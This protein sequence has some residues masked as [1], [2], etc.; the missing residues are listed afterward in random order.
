MHANNISDS[1]VLR[2]EGNKALISGCRIAVTISVAGFH[3]A[4]GTILL[5]R[6]R[7]DSASARSVL[8]AG[9]I[10]APGVASTQLCFAR[11]TFALF[12]GPS[13][14]AVANNVALLD[15]AEGFIELATGDAANFS[16]IV[17]NLGVHAAPFLLFFLAFVTALDINTDGLAVF[18]GL[19]RARVGVLA[20]E[21]FSQAGGTNTIGNLSDSNS[22]SNDLDHRGGL[23][24]CGKLHGQGDS[25]E[26]QANGE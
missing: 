10:S 9:L 21:A 8:R 7:I 5:A 6:D 4:V 12:D 22:L 2:V 15:P 3:V 19:D 25:D 24:V 23:S 1:Q 18:A 14:G 13:G 11:A 16:V 20:C 26:G 17:A